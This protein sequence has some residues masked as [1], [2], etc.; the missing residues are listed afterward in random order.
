M[1]YPGAIINLVVLGPTNDVDFAGWKL[2][3]LSTGLIPSKAVLAS[4][5]NLK[6]SVSDRGVYLTQYGVSSV[7]IRSNVATTASQHRRLRGEQGDS[8]YEDK[9]GLY[10]IR[11]WPRDKEKGICHAASVADTGPSLPVRFER[12]FLGSV[13]I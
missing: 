9:L 4:V 12:T 10:S 6:V 11:L 7:V 8:R 1:L 5:H 2:G 13:G 3:A